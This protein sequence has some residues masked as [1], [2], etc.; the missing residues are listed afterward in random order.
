M[1]EPPT[2]DGVPYGF[3]TPDSFHN[4]RGSTTAETD[5]VI[6]TPGFPG[7]LEIDSALAPQ[8]VWVHV[9]PFGQLGPHAH[10][11]R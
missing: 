10:W 11:R 7:V 8:A 3:E 4:S 9:T 1:I 6:D 2:T 5:I